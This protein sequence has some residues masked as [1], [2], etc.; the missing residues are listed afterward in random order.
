VEKAVLPYLGEIRKG[1]TL[2]SERFGWEGRYCGDEG[3]CQPR[4]CL[5]P[6]PPSSLMERKESLS[7]SLYRGRVEEVKDVDDERDVR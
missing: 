3:G 4:T 2:I 7:T 1:G 6:G 5:L